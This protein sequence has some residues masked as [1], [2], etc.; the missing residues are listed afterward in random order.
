MAIKA[1][2][3]STALTVSVIWLAIAIAAYHFGYRMGEDYGNCYRVGSSRWPKRSLP[4]CSLRRRHETPYSHQ[5][6]S[7]TTWGL[8]SSASMVCDL[9]RA[10]LGQLPHHDS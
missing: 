10:S 1:A 7:A 8:S 6:N 2:I 9:C 5:N 4:R 3:I